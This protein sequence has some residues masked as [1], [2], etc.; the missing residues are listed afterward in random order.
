MDLGWANYL[1][2]ALV[3]RLGR[4]VVLKTPA[5]AVEDLEGGT[6][7]IQLHENLIFKDEPDPPWYEA[8]GYLEKTTGVKCRVEYAFRPDLF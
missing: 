8:I 7:L 5:Y 3:E 4:D 2:S 6:L 1:S